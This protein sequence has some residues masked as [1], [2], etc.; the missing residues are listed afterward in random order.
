M[1]RSRVLAITGA[2]GAQ[3]GGLLRAVL[4][5]PNSVFAPRAITRNPQSEKAR[6]L[7]Q[8][9]A[10]VVQADL[11]DAESLKKAFE[12]AEAAFC[13][14]NYWELFDLRSDPAELRN[15]YGQPGQ[16]AVT[17][18]LKATLARLR[19]ELQDDDRFASEQPPAGVD[20][21]AAKLRGK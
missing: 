5:D 14:T 12:G 8:L 10:E 13:V 3:G 1:S 19:R 7:A 15:L 16:E 11:N 18:E 6:S 21:P 17:A 2:T 9:G 4:N 20:G